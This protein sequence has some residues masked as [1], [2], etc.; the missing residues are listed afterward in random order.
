MGSP[1]SDTATLTG[2]PGVENVNLSPG[3]AELR[4]VGTTFSLHAIGIENVTVNGGG[5]DDVVEIFDSTGDDTLV[6]TPSQFRLTGTP[7]GGE[8]FSLTANSFPYAHAYAKNGGL[9]AANFT[10]SDAKDRLKIYPDYLKM[11]GGTFYNRAKFFESYTAD[12]LGDPNDRALVYGSDATDVLWAAKNDLRVDYAA[13]LELGQRPPFENL[14]YDVLASGF[15]N[16]RAYADGDPN[17]WAELHASSTADVFI[18]KPHKVQLMNGPRKADG[19]LRG[20]EYEI[21]ARG[22]RN[23]TAIGDA[24]DTAKLYDS[25]DAGT[26]V[27]SADYRDGAT[28][29]SMSS[30]DRLLYEV[31]AFGQVGG[32]GF[33]GGLGPNHG[34]N[35]KNHTSAVDFTFQYGYWDEGY[36]RTA[37]Q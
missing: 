16:V 11:I 22:F 29:S 1:G 15:E 25:A 14:N 20:E 32:Y 37:G 35:A 24:E 7:E 26:D 5:G 2:G 36:F 12:G 34:L 18:A 31:L 33:N 17:D 9:D 10:G 21:T 30:P 13:V 8:A 4:R 6:A 3:Q 23:V 27:W 28:W 19:V